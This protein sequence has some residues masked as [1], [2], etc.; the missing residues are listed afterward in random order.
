MR[1]IWSSILL[2]L[3]LGVY[4]AAANAQGIAW[5]FDELRLLVGTGDTVTVTDVAGREVTGKVSA[6]SPTSLSLQVDRQLREWSESDVATIQRKHSDS[7][8]NGA[9]IGLAVGAGATAVLIAASLEAEDEVSGGEIAAVVAVYG[10]VGAAIG[11]GVD[12]LITRKRVIF[13]KRPTQ[14]ASIQV[15]PFVSLRRA[16]GRVSIRF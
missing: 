8:G 12:A 7:L 2:G 10:G 14:G 16:G 9:L 4:P 3:W 11:V 6:L 15:A 5:S 1:K 13:E